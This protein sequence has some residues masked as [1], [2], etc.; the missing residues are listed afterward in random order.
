MR[1]FDC[2]AIV[3]VKLIKTQTEMHE[4]TI[5]KSYLSVHTSQMR[6][7]MNMTTQSRSVIAVDKWMSR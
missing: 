7:S 5:D 2:S 4:Y 1:M 6:V 3:H